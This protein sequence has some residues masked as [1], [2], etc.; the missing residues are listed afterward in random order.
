MGSMPL[1]RILREQ[2]LDL[3]EES[4]EE[5][6][7]DGIGTRYESLAPSPDAET[8]VRRPLDRRHRSNPLEPSGQR[9]RTHQVLHPELEIALG[10]LQLDRPFPELNGELQNRGEHD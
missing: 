3:V 1:R 10:E 5:S 4:G 7:L 6:P 9:I 2:E 8:R